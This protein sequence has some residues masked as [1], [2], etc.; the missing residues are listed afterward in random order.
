MIAERGL[1]RPFLQQL[2][3][4]LQKL[5]RTLMSDLRTRSQEVPAIRQRLEAEYRGARD[6]GR[7]RETFEAW[8]EAWLTQVSVA[9]VLATVFVRYLED[10]DLIAEVW[11]AG[12]GERRRRAHDAF[13]LYF[14]RHPTHSEREY[15]EH[16]FRTVAR[17]P[18]CGDLLGEKSNPLWLAGPSGDACRELLAFWQELDPHNPAEGALLRPLENPEGDSRFLGDL[19]QDLSEEARKRYALLQ[20]PEF[21]ESFI[22]DRT[23]E[24]AL[25][26]FAPS[27]SSSLAEVRLLDPTCGSGHFLLGAFWRLFRHWKEREPGSEDRELARRAL[28][29]V[30]GVD[31]NPFAVAIA[32]FRLLLAAMQAS[33]LRRLKDAPDFPLHVATGDSLLHGS[34]TDRL[35]N[36]R[37]HGHTWSPDPYGMGD[38]QKAGQIL[39][40]QY[41]VVVGNPPYITDKDAAHNEEVRR[42]YRS[43]YQK[44]SLAVP[45][46]ERFFD[47]AL[48]GKAGRPAGYVGMITANSFMKREFGKELI[49]KVFPTVDLTHVVDCS[50]AYIPGHGTPTV[51]LFGRNRL[52][53]G[54]RV[55]AVLGIRGE[56]ATPEDPAR[57]RVWR[58][59]VELVDRPGAQ[60][61]FVSVADVARA[62]FHRHPW[63]LGGGGAL[64]LKEA[65][66]RRSRC[67][68]GSLCSSIGITS[69]TGEDDLYLFP[70]ARSARRAG[71]GSDS[72][73]RLVLGDLVRDWCAATPPVAL[74]PYDESF[75]LRPEAAIRGTMPL[76]WPCRTNLRQRKRFGVP[77]LQKGGVWYEW[78]E[79]YYDKLRTPLSI[80]FAFVATHNHFVLDRGGKVFNRSA[81]VIKLPPG[82]SEDDHLALLGLLNSSTANFWARQVC[83][84]K[85]GDYVGNEGAR[86]AKTPWEDRLERNG[87]QLEQFPIPPGHEATLPLARELDRLSWAAGDLLPARLV[88]RQTPSRAAL[89]AARAQE[90][91]LFRR[92]VALQEELDWLCYRLYGVLDEERCPLHPLE[93]LPEVRLGERAFEIAMAR[94]MAAGELETTWFA[95]HGST[96]VTEIPSRWPQSYRQV[97]EARLAL[98]ERDPYIGLLERPEYKRR[99]QR[100]PWDKLEQEALRNWLLDRLESPACWPR[101]ELTT[102]ARLADRARQDPDFLQV[103][104]LYRGRD[105]FDLPALVQ[106]LALSEAVPYLPAF[107]YKP[108]GL[109]KRQ[110]W[111][112][113]WE[114]Q[115]REDAGEKVG[116]IPVPP[117]YT[118]ADFARPEYWRLRGKLDVPKERFIHYPL[119]E[120]EADPSPVLAWAG[121]DHLQQARALAAYY[122]QCK[123]VEGWPPQR[124]MPLL[125]GLHDLVPWL[126]Q[127]HNHHDPETGQRLGDFFQGFVQEEA[128]G[129][130]WTEEDLAGWRPPPP[131]RGRGR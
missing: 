16:V 13:E 83:Q 91:A 3:R 60:N 116:P 19:Y 30:Y 17:L 86:V 111:E 122:L 69:V 22:L 94:K 46:L 85:G 75:Q 103:A 78:Q 66:E 110:Q 92:R 99:W 128:R 20:T 98:L 27:G 29:S 93:T 41:H 104:A 109:L 45:F 97:V 77:M 38:F 120:R 64:D 90:E 88:A 119:A 81:P 84:P 105:D 36:F 5:Q 52:P 24:P 15:L 118:S 7:T 18:G 44:F 33:G 32:R 130:G 14:R 121:W 2:L 10:N 95:R 35:G 107:R 56:P 72:T 65:I 62:T 70:D 126:L 113:T 89:D 108:S 40:R 124:L 76:L 57:G 87:T 39:D 79:L 50:G 4:D 1:S 59:I 53:V 31:L 82:A 68:L 101:L 112:R 102:T 114:L 34:R 23:L 11:L 63:S 48:P 80:A 26:E 6:R 9:W 61:E 25:A 73:L 55:R 42:H 106:E 43:A 74:W 47:L 129:F 49:E 71:A 117:K 127:W 67:R 37:F 96:P 58:S 8:R 115:R 51:I 125:A 12:Q 100:E 131:G 28:N 54:D 21:V 123:E